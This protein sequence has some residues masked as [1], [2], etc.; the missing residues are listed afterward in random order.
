MFCKHLKQLSHVK[1]L[2]VFYRKPTS[3]FIST[4]LP[5]NFFECGE[6]KNSKMN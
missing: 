6:L 2:N 1:G 3:K 5:N 4:R